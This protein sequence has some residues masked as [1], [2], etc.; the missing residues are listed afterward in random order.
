MSV[1]RRTR[2]VDWDAK[3]SGTAVYTADLPGDDV[4]YAALVRSPHPA[5]RIVSVDTAPATQLPGVLAAVTAADL[6]DGV[7]YIHLGGARADRPPFAVGDVHYIGQEVAAVAARTPEM[8]AAGAAAVRVEYKRR[9]AP[10]RLDDARRRGAKLVRPDRDADRNVSVAQARVWGDTGAALAAS[11]VVV[12]AE[13]RYP[14]VGHACMETNTTRAR[15]DPDAGILE[16][17][18]S[19]QAPYF[20][21]HEIANAVGLAPE[22]VVCREVFVGGGFGSK[23]KISEHEVAVAALA[24]KLPRRPVQISLSRYEEFACT[25]SRHA[26]ESR[27]RL[28]ADKEGRIRFIEGGFVVDN[29]AFN[30]TGPSVMA[31]GSTTVAEIYRP[32]AAAY[33]AQLVYTSKQPG[34][35]FRGYG[36]PQVAFAL[37]SLVDELAEELGMDP[38][39]LRIVNA[40]APGTVTLAGLRLQSVRL[41]ECLQAVKEHLRWDERRASMPD[42]HGLGVAVAV[43][44]SGSFA[45]DGSNRSSARVEIDGAGHVSVFFGGAD[46]GTGQKT[47]IAQVA[48]HELGLTAE[49]V[50]VVLTDSATTP[51]DMGAWSSRGT[52]FSAHAVGMAARSLRQQLEKAACEKLRVSSVEIRDGAAHHGE[53]RVPLAELVL[54]H[55]DSER[56]VLAAEETYLEERMQR[57][58]GDDPHNKSATYAFAAHGVEVAVDRRTGEVRVVDYV[59]AHDIGRA[60]NPVAA[61]GQIQGGVLMGLGAALGEQL[62]YEAGRVVN[63]AYINYALPRVGDAPRVR[64]VLV[65]GPD[66]VGPYSAKGLGEI[67]VVPAAPAVANAVYHAVGVRLRDLPITP[68]KVLHALR[69]DRALERRVNVTRRPREWWISGMRR[70]YPLGVHHILHRYGTRLAKETTPS[71]VAGIDQPTTVERTA[72]MLGSGGIPLAGGTDLLPDGVKSSA[73]TVRLVSLAGVTELRR[74]ESMPGGDLRLGAGAT[75]AHVQSSVEVPAALREAAAGIAGPQIREVATVGGNL[76]QEKRCW[77][78]RND[79]TCYKRGGATCPCYA[80]T[81]DHSKYHAALGAHR[82]QAV[83][84][85]DLATALVAL[86]ATVTI[87]R[88]GGHRDQLAV[89]H[90]YTGPGETVVREGDLV[91]FVTIPAS[92]RARASAFEKMGLWAG[93]FATVS[94]AVVTDLDDRGLLY[95]PAVVVGAIAPT[96]WSAGSAAAAQGIGRAQL[97]GAV[98]EQLVAEAHPLPGNGWKLDAA[99]GLLDRTVARLVGA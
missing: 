23:S 16:V 86:D 10:Y 70:A 19:T 56:G 31:A 4:A 92:S 39:E 3:T 14:Q 75:L 51:F 97:C 60:I 28:G 88:S 80:V 21:Q 58:G 66:P 35:Q 82:C 85:S 40:N 29:G 45:Y 50:E 54:E 1:G 27:V 9:S 59:A 68:D 26:F 57:A 33:D 22:A 55:A 48:A 24:L 7:R 71:R 89:K 77:F 5:A 96:P 53:A 83:T 93:D 98:S 20:I 43:H 99:V 72:E 37:E 11:S 63:P 67:T 90:F 8:A 52:F 47:V 25:K 84:P 30:H 2:D 62:I 17:W 78:Y 76:L 41:V 64:A 79:F 87:R 6:P 13:Y 74:I 61:E 15:W 81:G 36:T 38:L 18:T 94:V 42:G 95:S 34:G 49:S 44:G 12:A 65:E 32:D 46:A 73:A 69:G 91:E